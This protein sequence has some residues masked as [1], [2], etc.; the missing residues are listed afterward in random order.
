VIKK[1]ESIR[2][3]YLKFDVKGFSKSSILIIYD[4]SLFDDNNDKNKDDTLIKVNLIDFD[5]FKN[6]QELKDE[7]NDNGLFKKLKLQNFLDPLNKILEILEHI[8]TE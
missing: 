4:D 6:Y 7:S 3:E 2:E 1:I 8:K 5:F